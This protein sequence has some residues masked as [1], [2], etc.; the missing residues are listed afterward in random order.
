VDAHAWTKR[1]HSSPGLQARP[2]ADACCELAEALGAV[3]CPEAS[4]VESGGWKPLPLCGGG[5]GEGR[6]IQFKGKRVLP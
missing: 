3:R 5:P 4:L 6:E 2:Q 1:P